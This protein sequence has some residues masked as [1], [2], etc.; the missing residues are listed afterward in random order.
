MSLRSQILIIVFLLFSIG[1]IIN[2]IKQNRLELKYA[3]GWI[4]LCLVIG[5]FT[6]F[7]K[8]LNLS[9]NAMGIELP[10]NMLF[11]IGF[12]LSLAII[13]MLTVIVSSLANKL[14]TLTQEVAILKNELQKELQDK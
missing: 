2:K 11:F 4:L 5:V 6:V 12:C 7:P 14:K 8:L 9:A 3:L 10:I 13:F 1:F